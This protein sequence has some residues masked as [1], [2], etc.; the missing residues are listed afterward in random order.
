M[1]TMVAK[2]FLCG[3]CIDN[4]VQ[5]CHRE[6]RRRLPR[7]TAVDGFAVVYQRPWTLVSQHTTKDMSQRHRQGHTAAGHPAARPTDAERAQDVAMTHVALAL[8]PRNL[9]GQGVH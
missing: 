6:I 8:G 7:S 3:V 9:S 1:P 4:T 5:R 2:V